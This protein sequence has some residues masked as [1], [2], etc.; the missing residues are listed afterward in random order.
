MVLGRAFNKSNTKRTNL[1]RIVET[2]RNET[3]RNETK[4]NETKRNE[5]KQRNGL[6]VLYISV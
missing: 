6:G 4:R 1:L 5:A 3:K 2:K